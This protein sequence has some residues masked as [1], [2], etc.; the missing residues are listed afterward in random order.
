MLDKK[1]KS[2]S[3]LRLDLS[4]EAVIK[5]APVPT[6]GRSVFR[7]NHLPPFVLR[8]YASGRRVFGIY[9]RVKGG[10]PRDVTIGV[11]PN[12]RPKSA[13]NRAHS[14]LADMAAGIDPNKVKRQSLEEQILTR[15]TLREMLEEHLTK[16]RRNGKRLK[17]RTQADYRAAVDRYLSEWAAKPLL[18]ITRRM[19]VERHQ[20]ISDLH[21]PSVADHAFRV[22]R[23]VWNYAEGKFEDAE[24]NPQ[25]PPNP[26]NKL[27]KAHLWNGYSRRQSR[28]KNSDLR[29]WWKAVGKLD[30]T[31]RDYFR[32]LA[33]TG[34]R[35]GEAARLRW[36]NIDMVDRSLVLPDSKN[37]RD[38]ALPL[39]DYLLD[40]LGRRREE[41][42][43][44]F[45][46]PWE[47]TQ[48]HVDANRHLRRQ[49]DRIRD[50]TATEFVPNDCRRT[51]QSIAEELEIAPETRK[52]LMGHS[53]GV[54]DVTQGYVVIESARARKAVDQITHRILELALENLEDGDKPSKPNKWQLGIQ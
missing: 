53:L 42:R 4:D 31:V 25:L 50:A 34:M 29:P 40:L 51:F 18:G 21:G 48:G 32:F 14:I 37:R 38:L 30:Y 8:V 26:V 19:V 20:A 16:A 13:R 33:L 11:F 39:V 7:D 49:I 23:L 15:V 2:S 35:P 1:T 44:M 9:A 46:F 52:F 47:C 12:I 54:L 22:L 28:I 6:K 17:P 10:S 41:A 43:S 27:S 36:D 3:T 24:G 45:V 5:A